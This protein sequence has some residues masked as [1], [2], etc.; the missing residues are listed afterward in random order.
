M[1][2]LICKCVTHSHIHS[3]QWMPVNTVTNGP[4]KIGRINGVAV[5]LGHA[6]IAGLASCNDN[7]PYITFT[8]LFSLINKINN[9]NVVIASSN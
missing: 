7:T 5:L 6:Q 1:G 4:K 9:W 8:V 3:L 2:T